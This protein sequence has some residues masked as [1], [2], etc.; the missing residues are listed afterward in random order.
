MIPR[1][2]A[3]TAAVT[4]AVLRIEKELGLKIGALRYRLEEILE[5]LVCD[6]LNQWLDDDEHLRLIYAHKV[7]PASDDM[8][9]ELCRACGVAG[10]RGTIS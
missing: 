2:P 7:E 8:D 6:E 5:D 9:A 3:P 1:R 10:G 4:A